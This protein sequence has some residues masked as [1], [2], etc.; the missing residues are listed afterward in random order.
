[1]PRPGKKIFVRLL[2]IVDSLD[3]IFRRLIS[4]G[5]K[6]GIKIEIKFTRD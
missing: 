3:I 2:C 5:V 6:R 4:A 1:M